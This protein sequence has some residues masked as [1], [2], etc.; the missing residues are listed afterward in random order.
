MIL[1]QNSV[2]VQKYH[3]MLCTMLLIWNQYSLL[4]IFLLQHVV[5]GYRMVPNIATCSI[6]PSEV[7]KWPRVWL[8]LM[9]TRTVVKRT[10]LI[11]LLKR[12]IL[13]YV[14]DTRVGLDLHVM[15]PSELCAV[16]RGTHNTRMQVF[17]RVQKNHSH[18]QIKRDKHRQKERES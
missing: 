1:M 10:S 18:F 2:K 3:D 12:S 4:W 5:T 15:L 7:P 6:R 16:K 13:W 9:V 11:F 8:P 17:V 14:C